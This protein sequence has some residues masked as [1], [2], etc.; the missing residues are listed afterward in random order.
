MAAEAAAFAQ[1]LG[2]SLTCVTS[3]RSGSTVE[4]ALAR[5]APSAKLHCWRRDQKDNPY[6]GYLARADILIVTGESESMLAEAA[7]AGKPLYIY[8]IPAK[9]AGW[10]A[11]AAGAVLARSRRGGAAGAFCEALIQRGLVVPPR[12]LDLMHRGMVTAG[13]ALI[14]GDGNARPAAAPAARY[15]ALVA[16]VRRLLEF[17]RP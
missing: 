5:G 9:P 4:A 6:L 1:R 7:D 10:R 3:R 14:F 13:A 12:D 17:D 11:R 15:D 8:P 16:R 2:G